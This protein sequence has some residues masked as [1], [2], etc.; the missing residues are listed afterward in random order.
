MFRGWQQDFL[1]RFLDREDLGAK[2]AYQ[3]YWS[4]YPEEEIYDLFAL[5]TA[6]YGLRPGLLRPDD[7]MEKLLVPVRTKN[8]LKWLLYQHRSEDRRTELNYCL[9]KRQEKYGTEQMW[10]EARIGT[11]NDFALA[12][13]G[14]HPLPRMLVRNV[15]DSAKG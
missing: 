11:I 4:Q 9:R 7:P 8:P 15:V 3:Q 6:E 10:E 1:K 5:I 14:G 12:W 2:L 13:C